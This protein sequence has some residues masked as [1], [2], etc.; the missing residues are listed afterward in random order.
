MGWGSNPRCSTTTRNG[1][2]EFRLII[3]LNRRD[4]LPGANS[5]VNFKSVSIM[6]K[7]T[8][9]TVNKVWKGFIFVIAGII[10]VC[11]ICKNPGHLF[12]AAMVFA[13]GCESNI[14]KNDDYDIC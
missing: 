8:I 13:F 11:A 12:T 1:V 9:Q 6:S 2:I 5:K 10:A 3:A 7:E 14:V 4:L